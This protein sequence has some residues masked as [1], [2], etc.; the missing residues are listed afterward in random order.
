MLELRPNCECCDADLPPDSLAARICTFECTF[1]VSCADGVLKGI[2]PNCGGELVRRPI[3][4][5]AKLV[6]NPA[7]T[8]R[9][10]KGGGCAAA[11]ALMVA[12]SGC[13]DQAAGGARPASGGASSH[14]GSGFA[15]RYVGAST[16]YKAAPKVCPSPSRLDI[17]VLESQFTYRLSGTVQFQVQVGADGALSAS[18]ADYTL[19]GQMTND[20][21]EGDIRNARCGYHFLARRR[22]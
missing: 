18:A 11:L 8:V 2:C 12:L 13:A 17:M 14:G 9:K 22:S 19:T 21:L 5:A 20:K 3:R 15:N 10:L 1:C 4:P 6:N 16:R 7:S